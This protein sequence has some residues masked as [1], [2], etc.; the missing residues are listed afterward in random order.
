MYAAG[1]RSTARQLAQSLGFD[2]W[3]T[4]VR[5]SD[6]GKVNVPSKGILGWPVAWTKRRCWIFH[7]P[8]DGIITKE[9]ISERDEKEERLM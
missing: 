6:G 9:V 8:E 7:P 1:A 3:S 5:S 2:D 4:S